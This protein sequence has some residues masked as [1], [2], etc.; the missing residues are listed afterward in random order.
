M[1]EDKLAKAFA[2]M[3]RAG[4]EIR[5]KAL[6]R[7]IR[8]S[9]E[10]RLDALFANVSTEDLK[11]AWDAVGDDSFGHGY[12]CADIHAELNRRGEGRY[13]AV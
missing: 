6:A 8:L 2:S 3:M 10:M 5:R 11:A 7:E 9:R 13:C 1:S 12:D 4:A